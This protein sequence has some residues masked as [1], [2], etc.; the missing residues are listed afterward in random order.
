MG[1]FV[2][3]VVEYDLSIESVQLLSASSNMWRYR[4]SELEV[5]LNRDLGHICVF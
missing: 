4:Y 1:N 5:N 2:V 3:Y